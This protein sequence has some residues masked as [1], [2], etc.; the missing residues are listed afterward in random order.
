MTTITALDLMPTPDYPPATPAPLPV[1]CLVNVTY[2]IT[3]ENPLISASPMHA[4][5][6]K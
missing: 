5:E 3:V 1:S 6:L 4:V 2:V